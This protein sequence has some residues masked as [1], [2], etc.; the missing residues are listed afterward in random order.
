MLN[1]LPVEIWAKIIT[2]LDSCERVKVCSALVKL[3]L[4]CIDCTKFNTYMLLLDE[5]IK[6]DIKVK[7]EFCE[8]EID[9]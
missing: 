2:S 7:C 4:V 1:S 9:N 3:D 8:F 5:C 6:K